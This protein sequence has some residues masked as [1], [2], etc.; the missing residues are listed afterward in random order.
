MIH[1]VLNMINQRYF[2]V[3][4]AEILLDFLFAF[5]DDYVDLIHIFNAAE[6]VQLT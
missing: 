4:I 6:P 3:L 5:M 1:I 2:S